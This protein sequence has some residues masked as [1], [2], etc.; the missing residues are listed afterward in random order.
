MLVNAGITIFES[1]METLELMPK[2]GS[3]TSGAQS[4]KEEKQYRLGNR[5]LMAMAH[6]TMAFSSEALI[7][8]IPT[9][10]TSEWPGSLGYNN[11]NCVI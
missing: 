9:A 11:N 7:N 3:G 4:A 5:N 1:D 2:Y 8:K 6:L 10:K